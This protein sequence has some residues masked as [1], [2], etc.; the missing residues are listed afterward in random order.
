MYIGQKF[1]RW[2]IVWN[3]VKHFEYPHREFLNE[4]QLK[5]RLLHLRGCKQNQLW[6]TL[7]I[8]ERFIY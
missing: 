1:G 2:N 8:Q 5:F 6:V 3:L 7:P 4:R